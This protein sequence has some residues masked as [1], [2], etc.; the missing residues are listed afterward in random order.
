ML[1][2]Q[3]ILPASPM[4]QTSIIT[5][6]HQVQLCLEQLCVAHYPTTTFREITMQIQFATDHHIKFMLSLTCGAYIDAH[7]PIHCSL[8]Q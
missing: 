3:F 5:E 7:S 6:K 1:F 4:S 2:M 8:E